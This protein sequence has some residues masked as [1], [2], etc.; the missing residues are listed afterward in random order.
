MEIVGRDERLL[1]ASVDE[2]AEKILRTIRD[3]DRQASLRS[4]LASRKELFSTDCFV[5]RIREFV[6][7]FD[8]AGP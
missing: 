2:A 8:S 4:L 6:R 5:R 7:N 1:Y 3:P